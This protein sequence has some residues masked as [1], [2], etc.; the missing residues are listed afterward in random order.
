MQPYEPVLVVLGA[1]TEALLQ[2][3]LAA[4]GALLA[5][6]KTDAAATQTPLQRDDAFA[7]EELTSPTAPSRRPSGLPVA[8]RW[9][10]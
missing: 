2:E 6:H 4:A 3:H 8:V 10:K 5:R 7:A 1:K 9:V